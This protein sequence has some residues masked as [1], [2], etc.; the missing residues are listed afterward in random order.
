MC[1]LSIFQ[2]LVHS[3]S[4]I[5]QKQCNQ[6]YLKL[7]QAHGL[8]LKRKTIRVPLAGPEFQCQRGPIF[9]KKHPCQSVVHIE[10]QDYFVLPCFTHINDQRTKL[11]IITSCIPCT[12]HSCLTTR[13]TF[14]HGFI[15]NAKRDWFFSSMGLVPVEYAKT[16]VISDFQDSKLCIILK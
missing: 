7:W 9:A 11:K 10:E 4:S 16:I 2:H 6:V 1:I 5:R 8:I 12:Y 14:E 15:C 3:A 13:C